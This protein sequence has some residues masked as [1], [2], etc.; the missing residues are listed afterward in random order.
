MAGTIARAFA[1]AKLNLALH[2]TGRRPDGY[3]L[4]DSLVV[5]PRIGDR[6]T[7]QLT[8]GSTLQ[9]TG[10]F[11]AGTPSGSTN[12]AAR[13]AEIFGV[14]AAILLE[15]NLPCAAGLGGG[16]ADAAAVLR[17][18]CELTGRPLPDES[19]LL[20]LGADVPVCLHPVPQRMGGVGEKLE[21]LPALPAGWVALVNPGVP[22]PTSEVFAGLAVKENPA[23]PAELPE[24]SDLRA[25]AD[26]MRRET[27]NDLE[28]PAR[29]ISP[30]V[31]A[32]LD[33]LRRTPGARIA[34]MSGSGAT[35]FAL[36]DRE[37]QA[38]SAVGRV[39]AERPTWWS[40]AAPLA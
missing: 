32:A 40:A 29:A 35:C 1:P 20:A 3:H 12:L 23:M 18:L 2:V 22:M 7:A 24:W 13:A 14:R 39:H 27:R 25:L 9:V 6:I 10:P 38:R 36:Y 31:S 4:L 8:H 15:K 11:A 26:W 37:A 28:G 34:R 21:R 5:F 17:A 19:L 33:L 30:Q 16:S